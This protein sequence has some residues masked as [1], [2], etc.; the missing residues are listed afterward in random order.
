MRIVVTGATGRFGGLTVDALLRRGVEPSGIVAAGRNADRLALLAE[1]GLRVAAVDFDD[2]DGLR[3]VFEGADR[4]LLVSV[5][6]NA[7]RLE[8]HRNAIEA[9]RAG[10]V[11]CVAYTGY[12]HADISSMHP[13][14][15]ATEGML[16]DSG[17]PH[18]VLRNPPYFEF[19]LSWIPTW[20]ENGRILGAAGSGRMSSAAIADLADAAAVVLTGAAHEGAIYELGGDDPFTMAQFA[21]ELSRQT[22]EEIPYVDVSVEEYRES[23]IAAGYHEVVAASLARVD[24]CMAAG[25]LDN[26]TGELRRLRGRPSTTLAQAI[27]GAL[28]SPAGAPSLPPIRPPEQR[29]A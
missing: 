10:G 22:G 6:G 8:Q 28:R 5:R 26:D 9:A 12:A 14:H 13:E 18:A 1:R 24:S 25:E 15:Y 17:L 7:R 16:R 29:S 23:L 3:A 2:P 11:G 19:R 4:V 20:R 21:A 27:A